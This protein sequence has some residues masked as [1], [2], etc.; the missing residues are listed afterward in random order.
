M[1]LNTARIK[2]VSQFASNPDTSITA[3]EIARMHGL[4]Q[5]S[6]YLFMEELVEYSILSFKTQGKN[7]LYHLNKNNSEITTRFLCLI[8]N[9]KTL[10]FYKNNPDIKLLISKII[11][12]IKHAAVI[13]GSYANNTHNQDSDLDLYILGE[14]DKKEI[15]KITNTFNIEINIKHQASYQIEPLTQE[16]IKNHIMIK[17]IDHFVNIIINKNN[18]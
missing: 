18:K 15:T 6:V 13:F 11:P 2:M 10:Q 7:K 9:Y 5:K 4:N 1:L 16:I 3:S 14:Y 12:F 17:N 8:E